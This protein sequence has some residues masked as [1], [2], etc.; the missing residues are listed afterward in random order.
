M[1]LS[2]GSFSSELICGLTD[3][4]S[5]RYDSLNFPFTLACLL[6]RTTSVAEWLMV[7]SLSGMRRSSTSEAM[8]VSLSPLST[9]M[10]RIFSSFGGPSVKE[11]SLRRSDGHTTVDPVPTAAPSS[12]L[13]GGRRSGEG[14]TGGGGGGLAPFSRAWPSEL[15]TS[16]LPRICLF[17][18]L[19]ALPSRCRRDPSLLD[20]RCR[21]CSRSLFRYS[22]LMRGAGSCGGGVEGGSGAG[23]GGSGGGEAGG[24][25][26]V[27]GRGGLFSRSARSTSVSQARLI[28]SSTSDS[29]LMGRLV[30]NGGEVAA[31]S[32]A[33]PAPP[34]QAWLEVE[35]W[36]TPL[37]PTSARGGSLAPGGVNG[38]GL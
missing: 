26:G 8:K 1:S 37:W 22:S 6:A 12:F 35:K 30:G 27:A 24:G 2:R 31:R 32:L 34:A 17:F 25:R 5:D 36:G 15:C 16:K 33:V 4:L 29:V 9:L 20:R 21:R 19:W 11:R 38:L 23:G 7:T 14:A 13:L 28:S 18:S 3:W 10:S